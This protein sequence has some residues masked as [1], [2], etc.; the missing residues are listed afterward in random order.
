MHVSAAEVFRAHRLAGR[1]L[2]QRRPG[3]KD[4]ALLVDDDR[5]VRHR[6]H[7]GPA[8][9]AGSHHH[10][11][12]S[13]AG[14]RHARLVE[15]DPSEM[16]AVGK[17]LGL[18]RQI[19]PARVDQINAGQTVLRRDLLGAQMLLH[20]HR[21]IRAALDRR[22]V[23]D[24]HDLA[25][26]DEADPGDQ[27]RAVDVALVHAESR[28]RADFQKRRAGI[29]QA[30]DAFA[31]QQLAA[32]DM[33]FARLGRAALGCGAPAQVEFVD[34]PTPFRGIG[35]ALAA[36]RSQGGLYSRHRVRFP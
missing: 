11:D 33:T 12:L 15:E 17:D 22:V 5:L 2:H 21:I 13:D 7:I 18:V 14:R 29:D 27:P 20:R 30:G 3:E 8:R 36:L 32:G 25:A 35:V 9:G 1:R 23:G 19:G 4:R 31:R 26:V 28:E 10:R 24:D 34:E 16:V 6:R